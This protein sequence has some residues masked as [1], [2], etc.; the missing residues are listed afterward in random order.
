MG[1]TGQNDQRARS[2]LVMRVP[3]VPYR[4]QAVVLRAATA[5]LPVS[6]AAASHAA[7]DVPAVAA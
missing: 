7:P 6:I 4:W 2:N 1:R 5:V 3:L